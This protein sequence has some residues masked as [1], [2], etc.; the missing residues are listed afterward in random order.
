VH[1][2]GYNVNHIFSSPFPFVHLS[3]IFIC[4][5]YLSLYHLVN[6]A[7]LIKIVS[8]KTFRRKRLRGEDEGDQREWS[9]LHFGG[10]NACEEVRD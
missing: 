6:I 9:E 7:D 1:N 4:I 5:I 8:Y 3:F 10:V 2:L